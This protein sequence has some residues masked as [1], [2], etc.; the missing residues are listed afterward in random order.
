[1]K[2]FGWEG[3]LRG[4][5]LGLQGTQTQ[6][7][8]ASPFRSLAGCAH[9]PLSGGLCDSECARPRE[10]TCS[11]AGPAPTSGPRH[12]T[13]LAGTW[14]PCG[15]GTAGPAQVW[16]LRT[17]GLPPEGRVRSCWLRAASLLRRGGGCS[18]WRLRRVLSPRPHHGGPL[19]D[20]VRIHRGLNQ[21]KQLLSPASTGP[22]WPRERGPSPDRAGHSFLPRPGSNWGA[23]PR[24]FALSPVAAPPAQEPPGLQGT[25]SHDPQGCPPTAGTFLVSCPQPQL[26]QPDSGAAR[27][28]RMEHQREARVR[29]EVTVRAGPTVW[30]P[31]PPRSPQAHCVGTMAS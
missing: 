2:G 30:S 1:M 7:V 28:P 21:G 19:A 27:A 12:P 18:A 5:V 15:R 22:S 23:R 3:T 6:A 29:V 8:M 11:E 31:C 16:L 17:L 9:A 10:A 14:A 24:Q 13:P 25:H 20:N 26:G 4:G